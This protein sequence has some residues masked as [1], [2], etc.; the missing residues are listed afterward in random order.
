MKISGITC[1][2]VIAAFG[3][4]LPAFAQSTGF[5]ESAPASFGPL[6]QATT[7]E[8]ITEAVANVLGTNSTNSTNETNS[9]NGTD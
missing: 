5:V 3:V 2:A 4:A 9:T 1:A 7:L 6:E 8:T